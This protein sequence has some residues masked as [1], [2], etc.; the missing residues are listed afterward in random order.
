MTSP[1]AKTPPATTTSGRFVAQVVAL[2]AAGMILTSATVF[3]LVR[4]F[5]GDAWVAPVVVAAAAAHLLALVVR[6]IG[7]GFPVS[8]LVSGAGLVLVA[9]WLVYWDTAYFGLPFG[10]TW[11]VMANDVERAWTSFG[12]LSPP[13]EPVDGFVICA[14]GAVWLL[15]FL[16]DSIAMRNRALL[17]PML[18]ATA[19]VGF[20]GGVG[21]ERHRALTIGV[22]TAALLVFAVVHRVVAQAADVSWLGGGTR[23]RAGRRALLSGGTVFAVI[24]LGG[25]MV[26]GPVWGSNQDPIIDLQEVTERGESRPSRVVISPLVDIRGRLVNQSET[27]MFRVRA[28]QRSYWRLTSLNQFDGQVWTSRADYGA[29]PSV[30]PSLIQSGTSVEES[31]QE[32]A[33]ERLAAV[34]LP[35]AFE[36]R[37][38]ES[39][40]T[41]ISYEPSSSTLIVG[42]SLPSSNG[43][44]YTVS[45][46]LPRFDPDALRAIPLSAAQSPVPDDN[47]AL[48]PDFS[49]Q[50]RVLAAEVTAGATSGYEQAL[51]LQDYFRRGDF[52]Y[53]P[54]VSSGHSGNRIEEFLST[55]R[56]YCEQFA[57]TFAAMARSV[58]LPARVAVGFTVGESDPSDPDL[59]L[60]RGK[61]AHAWPEVFLAGA[62]WVPFEPTPGRG[63]PGAQNYTGVAE[64]QDTSG[65]AAPTPDPASDLE[66]DGAFGDPFDFGNLNPPDQPVSGDSVAPVDDEGG[67]VSGTMW[68]VILAIAGVVALILLIPWFKLVQRQIRHRRAADNRERIKLL[69]T[70]TVDWLALIGMT[71]RLDETHG[72][73]SRR[74][75]G[76]VQ[77]H[78]PDLRLLGDL[79]AAAAFAPV[80]P[81]E[82]QQWLA[83]TWSTSVRSEVYF[84]IGRR[85]LLA[86]KLN[87][88]PLF[89]RRR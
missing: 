87:P 7:W 59:Y 8:A 86:A 9:T 26:A 36:P 56:G 19:A 45:S 21:D 44:A 10:D 16:V 14:V 52:T 76:Q 6:R 71:P 30:L 89:K 65:P 83:R 27:V 81:T 88:R 17:E 3:C 5:E 51:A 79:T 22:F 53:D 66:S 46:A 54:G 28:D 68:A 61:H 80:E 13:V 55:R 75:T 50:V 39:D 40:T 78:T 37:Y 77:L 85:K 41:D 42:R 23:A 20:I 70:E 62:G 4:L 58:G 47:T 49:P 74:V 2:E 73:F 67:G 15:A 31:I 69:W 18:L 57:G 25:A 12:D 11:S 35:A 82:R 38:L 29:K 32:F 48:P 60:V 63:A 43:I 33:I 84:R 1:Q 34:W 64:S 24:A 72:E